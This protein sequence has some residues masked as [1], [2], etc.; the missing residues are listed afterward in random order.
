[1]TIALLLDRLDCNIAFSHIKFKEHL[2]MKTL[3]RYGLVTTLVILLAGCTQP[4]NEVPPTTTTETSIPEESTEETV[5]HMVGVPNPFVAIDRASEFESLG[6]ILDAPK[7]AIDISY[8]IINNETADISFFFEENEYTLRASMSYGG[9]RLHGMYVEFEDE[10]TITQLSDTNYIAT[11][12]VQTILNESGAVA[13]STVT[14][15]DKPPIYLT[16]STSDEIDPQSMI[17]LIS[18]GI[19]QIAK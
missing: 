19:I 13:M 11:L 3:S 10:S 18:D 6:F 4:E 7:G 1:M 15:A 14:I 8:H 5:A 9:Q 12:E 16:L 2:F 17:T